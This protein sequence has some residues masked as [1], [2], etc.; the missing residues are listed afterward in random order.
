MTTPRGESTSNDRRIEMAT[1]LTIIG[2]IAGTFI[3]GTIIGDGE[4]TIQIGS[5]ID[6][7]DVEFATIEVETDFRRNIVIR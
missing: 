1:L 5:S 2:F 4:P 3:F 7:T 6:H